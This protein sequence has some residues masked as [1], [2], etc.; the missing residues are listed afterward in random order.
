[1]MIHSLCHTR[2]A[3][4]ALAVVSLV[5]NSEAE[6][7]TI[8]ATKDTSIYSDELGNSNGVGISLFSGITAIPNSR[9]AL[10]AFDVAASVPTGATIDSVDLTLTSFRNS[11]S[12]ASADDVF[13]LHALTSDWGEAPL[14]GSDAGPLGGGG[15]AAVDGDATWTSSF[16]NSSSWTTPGGDFVAVASASQ[17]V[18]L[19]SAPDSLP[20]T[21]SGDGLTA[22]VQQWV[23]NPSSNFG[24]ILIGDVANGQR[25]ARIFGSR[26]RSEGSPQLTIAYTVVP[27]PSALTLVGAALGGLVITVS[28]RNK[29][30][31]NYPI[32]QSN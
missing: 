31:R 26:E 16:H 4:V 7:V 14:P 10:L 30:F 11:R 3:F 18:G 15:T 6:S 12:D 27:E 32:P 21:W 23:D 20:V 19:V 17:T 5:A 24:W 29:R 13:S 2:V 9:R 22:D 28:T 25:T 1:M 8:G